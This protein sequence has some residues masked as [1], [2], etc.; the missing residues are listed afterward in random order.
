MPDHARHFEVDADSDH[1]AIIPLID[2][3][4][5]D[6]EVP[7]E[8][9]DLG[10][11][12]RMVPLTR[13]VRGRM[14]DL[15]NEDNDYL[16]E[17][18]FQP[19]NALDDA[20]WALAVPL[21]SAARHLPWHEEHQDDV[22]HQYPFADFASELREAITVSFLTALR[23]TVPT[24]T[25]TWLS[26]QGKLAGNQIAIDSV[27]AP[28]LDSFHDPVRTTGVGMLSFSDLQR[29]A[30]QDQMVAL[31]HRLGDQNITVAKLDKLKGLWDALVAYHQLDTW[32][33]EVCSEAFFA[34]LDRRAQEA[35]RNA[36]QE[37]RA[38]RQRTYIRQFFEAEHKWGSS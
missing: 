33:E 17:W 8:L 28:L 34:K 30:D 11:N 4:E 20:S 32:S 24:A 18:G 38:D 35:T 21:F 10:H 19:I 5:V 1:I 22:V 6:S 23:L 16:C 26:F 7:Q 9:V 36:P 15:I 29:A 37:E 2:L 3:H 25:W 12:V 13:S 14:Q 27:S 31:C